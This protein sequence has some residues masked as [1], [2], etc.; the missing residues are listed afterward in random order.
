MAQ[1]PECQVEA[2]PLAA[3][4]IV[5]DPHD[6]SHVLSVTNASFGKKLLYVA[7]APYRRFL[8]STRQAVFAGQTPGSS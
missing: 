4:A 3:V 7:R 2:K 1:E 8:L 5:R 6:T